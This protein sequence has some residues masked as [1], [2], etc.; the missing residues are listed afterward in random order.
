MFF[1]LLDLL[2]FFPF[3]DATAIAVLASHTSVGSL[4]IS[5]R[6]K[7]IVILAVNEGRIIFNNTV[8]PFELLSLVSVQS[9]VV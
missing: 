1:A 3:Q 5:Q 8:L 4:E 9:N 6:I 2:N 7:A